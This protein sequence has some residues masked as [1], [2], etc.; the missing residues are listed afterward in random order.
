EPEMQSFQLRRRR[1]AKLTSF[2]GVDYR[3]LIG[4]IIES[5]EEDVQEAGRRGGLK[6]DEAQDLLQKLRKLKTKRTGI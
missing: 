6:P 2:F 3:D 5:I 1:A 4:E